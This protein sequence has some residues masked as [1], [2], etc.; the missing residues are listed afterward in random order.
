[1]AGMEEIT[2]GA[3]NVRWDLTFLYKNI[4]DPQIDADIATWITKAENFSKA[5]K[6]KLSKT[7]SEAFIEYIDLTML[8]QKVF[9]YLSLAQSTDLSNGII[10][11]KIAD[12]EQK[13]SHAQGEYLT[14]FDIELVA[15][16][17]ETLEEF[18]KKDE[19][20]KKHRPWIEHARVF[21]PHLLS[22]P[23]ESALTKRSPF[24]AGAWSE[25]YE[26][27]EADLV[28][29]WKE[30]QKT[31]TEML[32]IVGESKEAVERT[33]ALRIVNE[34]L[35][36]H[37]AKY[38]AQNLY[39]VVGSRATERRERGYTH[40]MSLR[41]KASRIPD[42]VV[43]ALHEAV[44]NEGAPLAKRFY[45]LKAKLLGLPQLAW[46]DRNA[47]MP[48]SD[49]TR[50]PFSKGVDTVL[51]AYESFSPTLSKLVKEFVDQ[52]RIDAPVVKGKR[53]GAFN[54]STALPDSGPVSYTFLN[55][56]GHLSKH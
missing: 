49:T 13:I 46:S 45:A 54:S 20:L 44:T 50:I 33:E 1:M 8:G 48:F 52:K 25:F 56:L 35:G 3:E 38:S 9:Y 51:A 37:F 4:E 39:M 6:G 18:Y 7:L 41:N 21:K 32:H 40:P 19:L 24:G 22:E 43:D 42:A 26:E 34:G 2:T 53:R 12:A 28:F 36:G 30:E 16:S 10:K 17:D 11:S 5:Y 55:Y 14:F 27:V 31:L 23:V 29:G 15:I 47:P